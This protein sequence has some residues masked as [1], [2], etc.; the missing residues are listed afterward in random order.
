MARRSS[1]I[2]HGRS[3]QGT[4]RGV[5]VVFRVVLA[6]IFVGLLIVLLVRQAW[7]GA[8]ILSP[9]VAAQTYF[10]VAAIRGSDLGY[11]L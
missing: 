8:A 10:A 1:E 2:G 3:H 7:V 11:R 5:F 4:A 9:F 6:V